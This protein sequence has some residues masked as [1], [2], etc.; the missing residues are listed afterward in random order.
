[1]FKDFSPRE[2][3]YYFGSGFLFFVLAAFLFINL[4]FNY[5]YNSNISLF[6]VLL[7]HD[8][9]Y[10]L[11]GFIQILILSFFFRLNLRR[12]ILFT[13]PQFYIYEYISGFFVQ[14]FSYFTAIP[15]VISLRFIILASGVLI[16]YLPLRYFNE[17]AN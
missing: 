1:L 10:I 13:L 16:I 7:I 11:F 9:F 8:S 3:K 17:K 15:S 4:F 14:G 12:T 2:L 6:V 5:I